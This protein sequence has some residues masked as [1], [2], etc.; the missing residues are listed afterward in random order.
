VAGAETPAAAANP[1]NPVTEPVFD[2]AA[3]DTGAVAGVADVAEPEAG[4]LV[5]PFDT[6]D[7]T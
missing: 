7:S 6:A 4:A 3:V 2:A 1:L 5:C